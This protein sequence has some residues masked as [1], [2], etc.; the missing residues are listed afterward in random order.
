MGEK[1]IE[2]LLRRASTY[3][4]SNWAILPKWA[5]RES[6]PLGAEAT[7]FTIDFKFELDIYMSENLD[8]LKLVAPLNKFYFYFYF[9]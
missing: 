5:E 4:S 3:R 6:N 9:V 8:Y 2:P 7:R 1:G